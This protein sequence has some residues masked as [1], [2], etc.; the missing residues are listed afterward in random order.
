MD[1]PPFLWVLNWALSLAG[2]AVI[3]S[4]V[5]DFVRTARAE[6]RIAQVLAEDDEYRPLLRSLLSRA[7]EHGGELPITEHEE[8]DLRNTVREALVHMA[9]ADRKRVESGLFAQSVRTREVYLRRVLYA[10]MERIHQHAA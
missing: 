2:I 10:S 8:I 1:T 5:W 6:R 4:T 7:R 3:A 9:P